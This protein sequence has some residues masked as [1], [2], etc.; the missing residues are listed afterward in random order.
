MSGIMK[1]LELN[2]I[3][4]GILYQFNIHKNISKVK[5]LYYNYTTNGK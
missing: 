3:Y 1:N 2:T 5:D 4:R